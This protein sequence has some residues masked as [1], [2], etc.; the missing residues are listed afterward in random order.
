MKNIS[1]IYKIV[2]AIILAAVA[3]A[4]LYGDIKEYKIKN[5]LNFSFIV[6]GILYNIILGKISSSLGGLIFPL[7]MFPLFAAGMIGAGDIKLFCAIGAISGFPYIIWIMTVSILLNGVIAF[8]LLIKRRDKGFSEL[9]EWFK[10]I[11]YTRKF[12]RYQRLNKEN[13]SVFRYAYGIFGGTILF[14]AKI[15]LEGDAFVWF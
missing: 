8:I 10:F 15:I 1:F 14:C 4:A 13:K 2:E 11:F 9:W 6:I 7:I 3:A 12:H 5:K